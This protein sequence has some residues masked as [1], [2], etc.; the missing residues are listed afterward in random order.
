MTRRTS[1]LCTATMTVLLLSLLGSCARDQGQK[2]AQQHEE[3][4]SGGSAGGVAEHSMASGDSNDKPLTQQDEWTASSMSTQP[5]ESTTVDEQSNDEWMTRCVGENRQEAQNDTANGKIGFLRRASSSSY[6]NVYV[7]NSD[8]SGQIKLTGTKVG[9]TDE[10]WGAWSPDG[11]KIAFTIRPSFSNNIDIYVI[12]PDGTCPA[13]L[14]RTKKRAETAPSWSPDGEK[15]AYLRGS[16]AGSLSTDLYVMQADGANQTRLIEAGDTAEFEG[17]FR[18]LAWSPDGKKIAFLRSTTENPAS[19]APASAAPASGPSGIYVIKP[20]GSGLRKL[21]KGLSY[22]G[23]LVWSPDGKKI[24]FAGTQG[25]YGGGSIAYVVN[26]DGTERRKLL[27]S[28]DPISS[29]AWSPDGKKIAFSNIIDIY[30]MNSDGSGQSNLTSTNGI[31]ETAPSW[32]PNGKQIAFTSGQV[33]EN[34][35]IYV[36]NTEGTGRTRLAENASSPSFAPRAG[37]K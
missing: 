19:S 35:D 18:L 3:S 26:A 32:S 34:Q 12:N 7:M 30:V 29:L 8:G 10:A 15:I 36:M 22:T 1:F 11:K 21:S 37:E 2:E 4:V 24:A 31:P 23:L 33:Y 5:T 17:S 13:N 20:N 16:S 28:E 14:T 9:D 27:S 6:P 25:A